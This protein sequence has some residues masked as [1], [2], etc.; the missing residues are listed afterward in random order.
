VNAYG[1]MA[2]LL[3]IGVTGIQ[4]RTASRPPTIRRSCNALV[5]PS[6]LRPFAAVELLDLRG[7][8]V[9]RVEN[10]ATL[11]IPLPATLPGG[12]YPARIRKSDGTVLTAAPI[13]VVR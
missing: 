12:I 5:L 8:I 1:A 11:H 3:D 6:S 9:F 13:A 2:K 7:R 4:N 10:P